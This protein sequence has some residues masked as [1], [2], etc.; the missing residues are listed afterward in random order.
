MEKEKAE[1]EANQEAS[2]R[3]EYERLKLKFND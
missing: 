2:D 1:A 3:A